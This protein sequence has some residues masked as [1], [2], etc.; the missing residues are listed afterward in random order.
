MF[1][2][3]HVDVCGEERVQ[4]VYS[5][6]Q[7]QAYCDRLLAAFG[8]KVE[9]AYAEVE[10]VKIPNSVHKAVSFKRQLDKAS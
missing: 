3:F 10:G 7:D 4:Y 8:Q 1:F 6:K 9:V 2:E 5:F